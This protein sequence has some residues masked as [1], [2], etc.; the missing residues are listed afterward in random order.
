MKQHFWMLF[1]WMMILPRPQGAAADLQVFFDYDQW[2]E[3]ANMTVTEIDFTGFANGTPI[4]DQYADVGLTLDPWAN[5]YQSGTLLN[6]GWGVQASNV[7]GGRFRA[8]LDAPRYAF[9][10][11][12]SGDD[13]PIFRMGEEVVAVSDGYAGDPWLF[14]GYIS[15]EPFDSVEFWR[16]PVVD[17][18]WFGAPV[19]APGALTLLLTIGLARRRR[20]RA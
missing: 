11:S 7:P 15:D 14:V 4:I 3:A 1:A 19:P 18:I 9:A 17:N 8:V 12:W 13:E 6:D 20:A 5:I 10:A 2:F 16:T